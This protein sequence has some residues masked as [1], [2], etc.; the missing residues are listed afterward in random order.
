MVVVKLFHAVTGPV[1]F[2]LQTESCVYIVVVKFSRVAAVNMDIESGKDAALVPGRYVEVVTGGKL[3]VMSHVALMYWV[4]TCL[5]YTSP[6]P[7]DGLL[8]RMPSSA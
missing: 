4:E 7:R 6:S 1:E 5:L 3:L 2:T 8:S